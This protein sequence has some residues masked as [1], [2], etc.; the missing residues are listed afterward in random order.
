M[1]KHKSESSRFVLVAIAGLVLAVLA[2]AGWAVQPGATS[3]AVGEPDSSIT[4][5][6]STDPA[7]F[8]DLVDFDTDIPG[9]EDADLG[10][11]DCM[12][13]DELEAGKYEITEDKRTNWT[14]VDIVCE[15]IDAANIEVEL[16]KRTVKVTLEKGDD[17]TCTFFNEKEP[18]PTPEATPTATPEDT[19][20]PTDVPTDTP[21]NTPTTGPTNTPMNT[22]TDV[23]AEPT[24]APPTAMPTDVPQIMLPDAG[25]GFGPDLV[26]SWY[27][28]ALVGALL[29]IGLGVLI[30]PSYD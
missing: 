25:S 19:A 21:E 1:H 13:Q 10:D 30:K 17:V 4:I 29:L 3:A 23:P 11:G 14:L 7:S 27:W 6:K 5:C 15:G 22:P 20:T 24:V 2:I 28:Y 9:M 18:A 16:A 12:T 8:G 26:L